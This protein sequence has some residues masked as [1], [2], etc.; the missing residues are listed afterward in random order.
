MRK[1]QYYM[2][3]GVV[4]L[5]VLVVLNL[6]EQTAGKLKLAIGGL[7]LPLFGAAGSAQ[8]LLR[9]T[10]HALA[11]RSTLLAQIEEL[12]RHLGASAYGRTLRAASSKRSSA[13]RLSSIPSQCRPAG[14]PRGALY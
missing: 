14:I 12:R 9:E 1:R 3:V 4:L 7:F 8:N 6:P 13:S 2:T 5:V 11:P 10:G